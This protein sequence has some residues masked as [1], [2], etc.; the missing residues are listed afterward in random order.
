MEP[1]AYSIKQFCEA[2]SIS[3]DTYFR[4]QRAASGPVRMK[5]GARTLISVE[6]AAAWRREREMAGRRAQHTASRPS[7]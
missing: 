4:M 1:K 3:V 2:H 6:A 5:V 7:A